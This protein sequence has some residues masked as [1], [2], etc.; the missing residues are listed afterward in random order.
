MF[1]RTIKTSVASVLLA[2]A[3]MIV[4]VLCVSSL[5]TMLCWNHLAPIFNM[6]ELGLWNCFVLNILCSVLFKMQAG[7]KSD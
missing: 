4:L 3:V 2:S 5:I 6:P 7:V 1:K